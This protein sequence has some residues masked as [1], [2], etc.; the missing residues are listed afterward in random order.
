MKRILY[1]VHRYAPFPGGSENYV[2][3]MAE[4]TL[5]R[6]H[7][8]AVFAGEHQGEL[9][10]VRVTSDANVLLEKW[11]LIV[12]H[13]ATV[14]VQDFVLS[15]CA[16]IPSPI[17]FLIILPKEAPIHDF[18]L[19]NIP[20]IGCSTHEDWDFLYA[21]NSAYK[22][23]QVSH[24]IDIRNS[25]GSPGF[26]EKY[27]ITTKYMFLSC[28]GFWPN[29]AMPELIEVFNRLNRDDVTLVLT[30]YDNRN[31]MQPP[32]SYRVKSIMLDSR[33]DVL[34]AISEAD[35]YIM[36]SHSEGFG[37]VILESM[38]NRT[39]W[40]ARNIAGAKLLSDYGFVY[41]N[42]QQLLDYMINFQGVHDTEM[43]IN[44]DYL[45]QNHSISNTVDDILE[46][47]NA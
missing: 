33:E 42:D 16:K 15:N 32:N 35:L 17:L 24:G 21:K 14:G 4:E 30:G 45:V 39:P 8:A 13:G 36:N 3:D 18:A 20:Y 10:G 28:G 34:S 44:R 22:G 27:N 23:V 31:G 5:R 26:R 9:N 38:A 41:D 43:N 6:G 29:K 19:E 12:V 40:A 47:C 46:V 11:D 1:V 37:L 7:I 2:R 25:M